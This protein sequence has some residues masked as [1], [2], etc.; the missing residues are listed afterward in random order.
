MEDVCFL[1]N[2]FDQTPMLMPWDQKSVSTSVGTKQNDSCAEMRRSYRQKVDL[3][4]Q[5]ISKSI[6]F[7][8]Q[9]RCYNVAHECLTSAKN[10]SVEK[11]TKNVFFQG[12]MVAASS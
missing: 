6:K 1:S 8:P 9:K 5:V 11:K 10:M 4:V 12:S 2:L 3:K 7:H